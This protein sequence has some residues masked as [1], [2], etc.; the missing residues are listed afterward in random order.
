MAGKVPTAIGQVIEGKIMSFRI[1]HECHDVSN[2]YLIF[3]YD[4][5][6]NCIFKGFRKHRVIF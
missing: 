2:Y 6:N 5:I 1:C 3:L 4:E